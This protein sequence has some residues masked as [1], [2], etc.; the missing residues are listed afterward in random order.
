MQVPSTG[1]A[2]MMVECP[3]EGDLV[4]QF[5]YFEAAVWADEKMTDMEIAQCVSTE[6]KGARF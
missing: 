5:L 4:G 3:V 2:T 6:S 1:L